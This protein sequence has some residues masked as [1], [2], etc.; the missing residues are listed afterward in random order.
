ML[1]KIKKLVMGL[2]NSIMNVG[3]AVEGFKDA[4]G[5][6]LGNR[7]KGV[8]DN[9][10]GETQDQ[11]LDMINEKLDNLSGNTVSNGP[12]KTLS[13]IQSSVVNDTNYNPNMNKIAMNLPTDEDPTQ[14]LTKQTI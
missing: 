14:D 11:K 12:S 6:G 13:P 2:F 4:K 3:K 5:Q 9:I 8:V 7:I 1:I 10:T